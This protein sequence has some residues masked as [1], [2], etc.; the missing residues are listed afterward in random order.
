MT[1]TSAQRAT[2][3]AFIQGDATL[4]GFFVAGNF[5]ALANAL[6][7][8][9][10]PDFFCWRSLVTEAEM[11]DKT[12]ADGTTWSWTQYVAQTPQE[13]GAWVRMVSMRGGLN[14]SLA[15]VR[16]GV[17]AIFSG[18]AAGP[19]AQRTHLLAI[20][21]RKAT[22]AEKAIADTSGGNGASATPAVFG[23]EGTVSP[24]EIGG[25]MA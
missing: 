24:G 25:I 16:A 21:K 20:G 13:Q 7:A 8:L 9:A 14:P 1:L 5:D 17:A 3:K 2:L 10:S 19:T 15:N 4:N 12:S 11:Y 22:V 23:S 18:G 6:N